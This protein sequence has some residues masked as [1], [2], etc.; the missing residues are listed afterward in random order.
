LIA[1][2]NDDDDV[3]GSSSISIIRELLSLRQFRRRRRNGVL[4]VIGLFIFIL[5]QRI[6]FSCCSIFGIDINVDGII[7]FLNGRRRRRMSS[8]CEVESDSDATANDDD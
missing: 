2:E 5:G 6:N 4:I 8:V 1:N 7:G 3:D